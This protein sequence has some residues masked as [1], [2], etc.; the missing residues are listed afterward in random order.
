MSRRVERLNV[1][2]RQEIADLIR[3]EMRDPR[4]GEL[5]SI[6]R[7]SISPDL[8]NG[9][10]YVSVLGDTTAKTDT[11]R[12]FHAAAPY[13]RRRLL[14]RVHIRRIPTLQ[15]LLDESIEEAAHVL[16]LMR[17][18]EGKEGNRT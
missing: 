7:V 6:T 14:E 12:A 11:M 13:L 8:E 4:L 1:L 15:F 10:V 17:Q 9:T 5:V 3:S 2:F 16:E 18:V